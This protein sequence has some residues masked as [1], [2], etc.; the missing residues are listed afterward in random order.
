MATV[1]MYSSD[2]EKGRETVLFVQRLEKGSK[3]VMTGPIVLKR[4]RK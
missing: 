4:L 1:L 2:V 3:R